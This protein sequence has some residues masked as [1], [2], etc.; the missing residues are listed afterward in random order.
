MSKIFCNFAR[1]FVKTIIENNKKHIL[2]QRNK[3][4]LR[5]RKN[6]FKK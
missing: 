2:W 6:S 3:T 5:S 1:F 4:N